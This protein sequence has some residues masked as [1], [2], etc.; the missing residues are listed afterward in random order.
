VSTT[1]TNDS[2]AYNFP[3]I[4]PGIYKLTASLTGF[5]DNII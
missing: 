5:Q 4:L 3:A 2:G 1:I